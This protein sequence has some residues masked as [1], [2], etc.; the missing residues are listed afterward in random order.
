[1]TTLK[2]RA[3]GVLLHITSLPSPFG[4]GDLGPASL[5]FVDL[6]AKLRQR[7]WSILP[8][9][10]TQL[11]YGNSPY[12]NDSA[13]AGNTLLISPE[14]LVEE[15]L[16][17][18]DYM[19]RMLIQ[20]T[21]SVNYHA[22][23]K[24]KKVMLKEAYINFK[25]KGKPTLLNQDFESFC[26]KEAGWLDDYAL[27]K[28]L[29]E[30]NGEPW[31]RWP[32]ALRDREPLAL[33]KKLESLRRQ[34]EEHKFKQHIFFSQW[35]TL[36]DWCIKKR[37]K[38]IGDMPFYVG[39]NSADVWTHPELFKL[40]KNKKPRYV[41]GVP[42]DYFSPTG[43]LWGDPVYNW[44][45]MRE[46]HFDWWIK[47]IGHNLKLC[48]AVRFDHFRGFVAYWQVQAHQKTAKTG[49]WIRAPTKSFFTSIQNVFPN[50]PFIAEDLGTITQQVEKAI[51]RIGVPG[52]KVL[53]FAFDDSQANPHFP[54][55]FTKNTVV[56][57]GTHDT[58][59][60]KGWYLQ[61]A[62][63]KNKQQLSEYLGRHVS[64]ENV[65]E[66]FVKMAF[67][68]KA[69]LSIIQ[70]QDALG[71]DAETRMNHPAKQ[72]GNWQWRTTIEQLANK[73]IEELKEL[74]KQ[75]NR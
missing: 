10:P 65:S 70:L 6:L 14:Q 48:D 29:R 21:F 20:P 34:I 53:L 46:K 45:Q 35:R 64:E 69:N 43:Q 67:A 9:N 49:K 22:V 18:K 36:K 40:D 68:S 59:T 73:K 3:S 13:F 62:T 58:N 38:I 17:S 63:A 7:Y 24:V 1:M 16:L 41:G 60:V 61:E 42:P 56:Y 28:S 47:R 44:K 15:S 2:E 26:A 31:Y 4:I 51:S 19:Q 33:V 27:Y 57:T 37:V 25:K 55:N 50:L 74:T 54:D 66:E 52:M 72:T 23:E 30:E 5:Q 8:V 75:S 39:Y 11:E 32:E 12:K 71:L